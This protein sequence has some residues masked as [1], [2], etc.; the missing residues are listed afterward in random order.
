MF[1]V[2][3]GIRKREARARVTTADASYARVHNN[4]IM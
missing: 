3:G 2:D 1:G 4:M